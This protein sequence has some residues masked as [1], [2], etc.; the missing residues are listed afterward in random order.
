MRTQLAQ[1]IKFIFNARSNWNL[2]EKILKKKNSA[3]DLTSTHFPHWILRFF[4]LHFIYSAMKSYC[5]PV[6]L[7]YFRLLESS[8]RER[9]RS[10]HYNDNSV[11]FNAFRSDFHFFA[12]NTLTYIIRTDAFRRR[13]TANIIMILLNIFMVDC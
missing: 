13:A 2:Q 10:F 4:S 6:T 5:N 11:H 7:I 1:D 8:A 12:S 9:N 3:L